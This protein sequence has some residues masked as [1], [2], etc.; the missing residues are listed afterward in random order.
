MF[1]DQDQKVFVFMVIEIERTSYEGFLEQK[2]FT[3]SE[4]WK[5]LLELPTKCTPLAWTQTR[6]ILSR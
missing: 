4:W 1:C 2:S 3:C 5:S 6:P